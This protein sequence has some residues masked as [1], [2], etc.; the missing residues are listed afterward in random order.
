[1]KNYVIL[2]TLL[3]LMVFKTQA[4]RLTVTTIYAA[5]QRVNNEI[6]ETGRTYSTTTLREV[7]PRLKPEIL[8]LSTNESKL[9]FRIQGNI[10]SSGHQM[11]HIRRIRYE[12]GE[13]DGVEI[14]LKYYVE[15]KN[16]PGK[17]GALIKG[18]NYTKDISHRIPKGVRI[19]KIELYED[20][21]EVSAATK[22]KCIAVKTFDF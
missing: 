6:P 13:Q 9:Q 17:E 22:S 10:R 2:P 3:L 14:T 7:T 20:Y 18:Y 12:K 4:Q 21:L 8:M 11:R 16:K 5:P 1:V 15:I 19:V